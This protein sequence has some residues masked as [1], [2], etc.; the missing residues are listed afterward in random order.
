MEESFFFQ[1]V[2]HGYHL[3]HAHQRGARMAKPLQGFGQTHQYQGR[4]RM[5]LQ[6]LGAGRQGDLGAM[7]A[8]HAID[9]DGNHA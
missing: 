1:R 4:I 3:G 2:V 7:V 9:S 6:K 8:P 5:V